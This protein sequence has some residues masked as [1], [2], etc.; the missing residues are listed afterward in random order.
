[1]TD[2]PDGVRKLMTDGA[3]TPE[4]S[5]RIMGTVADLIRVPGRFET[6]IETLLGGGAAKCCRSR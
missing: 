6:A 1:M 3:K 4:L 2:I 5:G